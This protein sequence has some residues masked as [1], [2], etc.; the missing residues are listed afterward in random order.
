MES[1]SQSL[2]NSV[3]ALNSQSTK[4]QIRK[5]IGN[6]A[7]RSKGSLIMT[8]LY[9]ERRSAG[10]SDSKAINLYLSFFDS[11]RSFTFLHIKIETIKDMNRGMQAMPT[12]M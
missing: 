7:N 5:A 3:F 12:K 2:F 9:A 1:S 11:Y 4:K 8:Y 6:W 10:I